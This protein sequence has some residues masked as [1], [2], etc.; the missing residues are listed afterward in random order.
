VYEV[1]DQQPTN[2]PQ[3]PTRRRFLQGAA[4]VDAW[5]DWLSGQLPDEEASGGPATR[6]TQFVVQFGRPAMA[7][8]FQVTLNA[9]D[10]AQAAEPA[11][12][13]LDLVEQLE[14]QLT[15]Y[16]DHSEV[17]QLNRRAADAPVAVESRLFSLLQVALDLH[18]WT[19]G[20]LDITTGP[21]TKAWGFYRRQGRLPGTE[22]VERALRHVGSRWLT[23]NAAG[24]TVRFACPG[25]ELNLG[26]IG[27]GYALDRCAAL[28]RSRGVEN[29]LLHGGQSSVL[30]AGTRRGSGVA[31]WQVGVRH[32]L[33]PRSRLAEF[34]LHARALGTSGSGVQ[35]FHH[36]GRRYGHIL[37]PRTGYPA[38]G[39][40][41]ATALAPDAASADALSTAFYVMGVDQTRQFCQ[42]HPEFAALLVTPAER[43]GEVV[44]HPIGLDDIPWHTSEA[45]KRASV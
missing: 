1:A 13:A 8:E 5:D 31:G 30:A 11:V 24:Q 38:E 34:T 25:L 41:A 33:R 17:S 6:A 44:L 14:D 32:P 36:Q 20:A 10:E 22:E 12:E 42:A 45:L 4:A 28:L 7:C 2:D 18:A 16:R 26:A 19:D 15:V 27:K 23:L 35:F 3:R 43:Q 39:V 29:F 9:G 37:D 21:L 40:L